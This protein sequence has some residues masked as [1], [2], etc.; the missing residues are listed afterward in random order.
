MELKS[1]LDHHDLQSVR[2]LMR[3]PFNVPVIDG[4]V[5]GSPRIDCALATVRHL[6]TR[7]ARLILISHIGNDFSNTASLQPV[8]EYIKKKIQVSFVDDVIGVKAR[9]A[10]TA[11]KDGEVLLLENLRRYPGEGMNDL[12]F[13]KD[14]AS[15]ADIYVNDDFPAS[16]RPHASLIGVPRFI[17]SYAGPCF[18]AEVKGLSAALVPKSPSL[19]ILGGAKLVTKEK[20][21]RAL[22]EKYD[23]VF[24]GGALSND[25]FH[26][27]GFEVGQSIV[28]RTGSVNDLLHNS[29]IIL[30]T[31]VVVSD[32][33]GSETKSPDQVTEGETI[34]DIGPESIANLQSVIEKSKM[35]LWNGPMGN[36]E[37]GFKEQTET[38]AK[39]IA[40]AKGESV[41]GG[42]DTIA[43][44]E[45][46]NLHKD[47]T[48]VSTAGGAM[49]AFLAH[50]TLPGIDALVAG[51]GL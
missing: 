43:S 38:L 35:V 36:F 17:P 2:V 29:K 31:D 32:S 9:K 40:K 51:R 48:F 50:G 11:L 45:K 4:K 16:H 37:K 13:A 44:I 49:L 8:Y 6:Q 47:F 14:L 26:A 10:I 23:H 42:G 7:G 21:L 30:P 5:A 20:L 33:D 15:L 24:V 28:S 25:F 1:I 3:V 41:V 39:M 46:L 34:V 19:A 27:Q 18:V 12:S 22:L